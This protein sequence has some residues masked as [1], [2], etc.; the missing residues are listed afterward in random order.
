MTE[1][2]TCPCCGAVSPQ[3]EDIANG[4]CGMCHWQTGD[5]LLGPYHMEAECAARTAARQRLVADAILLERAIGVLERRWGEEDMTALLRALLFN[6]SIS[7]RSQA[8]R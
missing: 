1:A 5:P 6:A 4:Y 8:E 7:L 2:F 3:A